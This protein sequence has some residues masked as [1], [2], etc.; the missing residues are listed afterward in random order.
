MS[1]DEDE[2]GEEE[3]EKDED[4]D[5]EEEVTEDLPQETPGLLQQGRRI[6]KNLCLV[7]KDPALQ[8]KALPRPPSHPPPAQV[9]HLDSLSDFLSH[10]PL[11]FL[12]CTT[13]FRVGPSPIP[14]QKRKRERSLRAFLCLLAR[15][16]R[17][18]KFDLSALLLKTTR[19]CRLSVQSRTSF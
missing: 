8:D 19:S 13:L 11:L 5:H 4:A 17:F 3:D 6:G 1:S 10:E 7:P 2:V 18:G 16:R 12:H 9:T 15:W 14:S